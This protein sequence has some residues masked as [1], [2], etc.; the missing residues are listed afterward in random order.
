[1]TQREPMLTQ[2]V[3]NTLTGGGRVVHTRDGY[4]L[5]DRD[6]NQ[7]LTGV[8]PEIHALRDRGRVYVVSEQTATRNR[9]YIRVFAAA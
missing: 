3:T 6:N 5:Y 1:M 4:T 2:F 8:S 9:P 7:I